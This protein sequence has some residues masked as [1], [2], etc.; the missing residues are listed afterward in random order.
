MPHLTMR[1]QTR[2]FYSSWGDGPTVLFVHAWG[3]NGDMWSY[4]IPPL[5]AAGCRCI[6]FDRRGSGRSD[7]PGRGYDLDSLA[8]DLSTVLEQLELTDVTLVG[9]SMGAAEAVRCLSRR[10]EDAVARL[11]LGAPTTPS[12]MRSAA[13]PD[14]IDEETL[15]AQGRLMATD[16]GTWLDANGDGYFGVT[17]TV[18][19]STI[20][21]T[22]RQIE[23]TSLP[24]LLETHRT[25]TRADLTTDLTTID[26]PTLIIHG[27]ADASV[28]VQLGQ[29][30]AALIPTSRL[31]V[32]QGAGHGCYVNDAPRYTAELLAFVEAGQAH[33]P[34]RRLS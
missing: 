12:L 14:G 11:V 27:D 34:L 6:T 4:Q 7:R 2:L 33:R 9:H 3:L 25:F 26:V 20:A 29:Q 8:G 28:P 22:R 13:H 23:D 15:D 17:P 1:D 21:W 18:S 31:V 10:R 30:T 24:V 19:P 16:I 32:L 5:V